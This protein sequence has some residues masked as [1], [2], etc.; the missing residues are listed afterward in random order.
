MHG[1]TI[2][3]LRRVCLLKHIIEG[4]GEGKTGAMRRRREKERKQLLVEPQEKLKML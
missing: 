3:I 1:A 4:K 2:R